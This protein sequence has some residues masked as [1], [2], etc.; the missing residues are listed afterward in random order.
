MSFVRRSDRRWLDVWSE[1]SISTPVGANE[2][3]LLHLAADERRADVTRLLLDA[4]G[5]AFDVD[6]RDMRGHAPLHLAA[7]VGADD[8]CARL[9]EY[10]ADGDVLA[11]NGNAPLHLAC[12]LPDA[13]GASVV[14]V[15]LDF[16]ADAV[17]PTPEGHLPIDLAN[18]FDN[19]GRIEAAL[20]RASP[21]GWDAGRGGG[22]GGTP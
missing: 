22:G 19:L 15:L 16:G 11:D 17:L 21:P 10:G 12:M 7:A 1:T 8:A 3:T 6:A 5:G 18:H 13:A 14:D 20:L 4:G 9:L 2:Y